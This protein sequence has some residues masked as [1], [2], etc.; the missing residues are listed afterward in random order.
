M[1]SVSINEHYPVNS[2]RQPALKIFKLLTWTAISPCATP[3]QKYLRE[4]ALEHEE[5]GYFLLHYKDIFGIIGVEE[6]H[7][8]KTPGRAVIFNCSEDRFAT[9]GAIEFSVVYS[10]KLKYPCKT[11]VYTPGEFT[12]YTEIYYE[13]YHGPESFDD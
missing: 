8:G 2:M 7:D 3:E 11:L 5:M 13:S 10:E 4:L 9:K 12:N 6:Y 1:T